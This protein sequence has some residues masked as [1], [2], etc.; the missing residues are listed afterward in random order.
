MGLP[1]AIVILAAAAPAATA[2]ATALI[3]GACVKCHNPAKH[4]GG[5][6]LSTREALLRGGDSGAAVVAGRARESLLY[7]VVAHLDEPAM[8][9]KADKLPDTSLALLAAWIDAG[10]RYQ[11]PLVAAQ[12][13]EIPW[14]F[15]PLTAPSAPAT[16]TS[17]DGFIDQRLRARGLTASPPASRRTLIRR[18]TFDLIGLPPTP[19][20][21][22]AFERDRHPDAYARLVDR[23]LASPHH[24]ERWGRHWLDVAR[25]ADSSGHEHDGDRPHAWRYCYGAG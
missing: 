19:E 24:G 11:R 18:A 23:L 6:D 5:L 8:P 12:A 15:R 13:D 7:R 22:V 14:A 1:L 20:E 9:Q 4:K 10:A 3:E 17:I 21:I 2:D 25:Y 16:P